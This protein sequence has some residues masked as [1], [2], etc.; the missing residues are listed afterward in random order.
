MTVRQN[1]GELLNIEARYELAFAFDQLREI[2][3]VLTYLRIR[4]HLGWDDA[5]V[6]RFLEQL[7]LRAEVIEAPSSKGAA[8]RD[9]GDAPILAAFIQ[10]GADV[11]VSGDKDLLVLKDRH[12]I[13]TPAEF[14][15]R[16]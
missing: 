1:L 7:Y 5:E 10:S 15:R 12:V 8:V 6:G 11:L 14:A 2:S 4:E 9:P 3:R 16:I 13:E